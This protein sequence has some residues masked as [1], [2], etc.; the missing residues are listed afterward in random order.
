MALGH[1]RV[2]F[3]EARHATKSQN[4]RIRLDQFFSG[5]TFLVALDANSGGKQW[6]IPVKLPFQH[7][8][9]LCYA[10]PVDAVLVTGTFNAKVGATENLFYGL[11]AFRSDTGAV[12]WGREVVAGSPG[13]D[14][15]EQWQHPVILNNEV[16]SKYYRCDLRTGVSLPNPTFNEGGGCGTLSASASAI[17]FRGGNPRMVDLNSGKGLPLNRVSRPGCFIN[18]IPAGGVV[19]VPEASAGCTCSYPLQGSFAYVPCD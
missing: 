18:I 17:F 5:P 1:G 8:A 9:Y 14:H 16:L 10:P 6:E 12:L 7:I 15:G 13:G 4:G 11:R 3:L 19:S 2:F